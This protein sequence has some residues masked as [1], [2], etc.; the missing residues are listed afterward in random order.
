[1]IEQF[2]SNIAS[3]SEAKA[4]YKELAKKYHPD[5]GGCVETMKAINLQYEKVLTGVYQKAGKSI[6][7]IDDLLEKSKGLAEKLCEIIACPCVIVELCGNWI[8]ITGETRAVKDKLKQAGFFWAC[9]KSAWYWRSEESARISKGKTLSLDEI[10]QKHGREVITRIR[11][12][13]KI[14]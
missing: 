3:E 11:E 9:K 2:F 14:A 13:T 5:L 10:R 4:R 7:E 8:W 12:V 6:T 1:M